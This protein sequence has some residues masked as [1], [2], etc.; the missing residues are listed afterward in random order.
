MMDAG[1]HPRIELMTNS[2]V[3]RVSGF[4]GNFRVTVRKK[5]RYVDPDECNTCGECAKVCPVAVPDE[6]QQGFSSRK[7]IYL[8]FP[9]AVPSSYV[10][11]MNNCLGNNPIA[12]G[13]CEEV[14]EKH[15][16]DYDDHDKLVEM[17]IGTIIVATGMDVYDP[18]ELD[19]FG[20]TRY[21]NVI[22]AMEFERLICAGGPSEGHFMRPSDRKLPKRVGFIQCVGSRS[23]KR[24]NPYCSNVCCMVTIKSSLL[25]KDHYPEVQSHVFYM[26]IR[27][28]GKQFEDLYMRSKGEGVRYI[29]GIPGEV[30]EDP[31]TKSLRLTVENTTTGRLEQYELDL[32]VLAQGVIPR[33]DSPELRQKL[34]LSKTADGFLMEAHPKLRPVDAPTRGIYIAG[35]AESPKD[36]KDCV[37]QAG[38][39]AARAS[40][41]LN[42]G[43][44]TIEAITSMIDGEKCTYCGI[45]SKVCSYN[46]IIPPDRKLAK[47]PVVIEAACAGC[48][49][50]G[51][52]CPA[53]AITMRHFSDEMITAQ[54]DAL[55]DCED[56]MKVLVTFAC[57]WCSYAGGDTAGTARLQFPPSQRLIRT[58]CSG[59]VDEKFIWHAFRNGAPMVLVSG[60]HFTDCHYISAVTWTQRRIDKVWDKME[61]LGIR[62][63]RLQLE[64]ISAAEGQKFAKVM[65]ELDEMLKKV[66]R[67]EVAETVKILEQEERKKQERAAKAAERKA[68]TAAASS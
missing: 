10:L 60:C 18:T 21:E 57:N 13:K 43:R 29:R 5:A 62:P 15:C 30:E 65:R 48:G 14:C 38:A 35:C 67:E 59:R 19:E 6:Y 23:Q 42:T 47:L 41:L 9:Q 27:A 7:A 34:T 58:M 44:V 20:Y 36:I 12:C 49:T 68:A 3:E 24:G 55:L 40:I 31:K 2:E 51:A 39:A 54:V 53:D 37:S 50:C 8:P 11:N 17:D 52:E 64:W 1:R 16:I 33:G 61:R 56:P 46:A 63:E 22:T 26:D 66:T 45:C 28:F 4:A 32:L 25:L